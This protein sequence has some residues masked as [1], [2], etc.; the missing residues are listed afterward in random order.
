MSETPDKKSFTPHIVVIVAVVVLIIAVLLW[1]KQESSEPPK[2]VQP[3]E[4]ASQPETRPEPEAFEPAPQPEPVELPPE[5]AP[6]PVMATPEP[7]PVD[8]S[9]AAVKTALS[10]VSASQGDVN[11]LL[12][13]D[14]ILNRFVVSVANIADEKI[15]PNHRIVTPPEQSFRVYRQAGKQWIDAASYKRYTPYVDVLEGVDSTALVKLFDRY[16]DEIQ[17]KYSE[18]GDPDT[19]FKSVLVD[20]IDEL[21]DT[22]E[23]PVPVEVFTDSV[24]YQYA[25]P[26][27]ENLSAPQK[28]LLRTGPDNMRRIKAKLRELKELLNANGPE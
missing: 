19:P 26:R 12:I 18:I 2:A 28:Q 16:K 25:D 21:L 15:A 14:G 24:M 6:E 13:D 10:D 23:V 11:R 17:Q 5:Q 7:E 4:Q 1:P 8:T 22:P 9:D 20:A 3:T 27:L